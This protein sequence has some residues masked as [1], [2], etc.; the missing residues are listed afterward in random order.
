MGG[1]FFLSIFLKVFFKAGLLGTLEEMQ[2]KCLAKLINQNQAV[3]RGFLMP[4]EF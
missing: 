2:D 4:V 1:S 3:Y